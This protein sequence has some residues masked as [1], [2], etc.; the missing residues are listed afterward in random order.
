[1]T[2]TTTTEVWEFLERPNRQA[3]EAQDLYSWGL[4]CDRN[5]NP[6]LVFLDLIGWSKEHY[7]QD[8]V[9]RD[10]GYLGYVELDHLASALKEYAISPR[11]VD[12]WVSELMNCEGV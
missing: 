2:E 6:F 9:I 11:E 4:N 8:L 10:L 5:A 7:G 12:A 1:M 3:Q